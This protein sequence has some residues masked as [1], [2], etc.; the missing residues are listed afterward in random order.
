MQ[1]TSSCVALLATS[2]LAAALPRAHHHHGA[3]LQARDP[4]Q[5]HALPQTRDLLQK[6]ADICGVAPSNT[7]ATAASDT[8]A[9]LLGAPVLSTNIAAGCLDFC[10]DV[11]GCVSVEYGTLTEGG[12]A[13][14]LMFTVTAG[15]LAAPDAGE[16]LLVFDVGCTPK[17]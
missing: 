10:K 11:T 3:L 9:A 1:F 15:A 12:E 17:Y 8:A 7:T 2:S 6:R 14:C 4:L 13:Q 16:S 5:V